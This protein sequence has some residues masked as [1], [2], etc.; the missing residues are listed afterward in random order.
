M[1][2]R[3]SDILKRLET[4]ARKRFGQ[5]FL[6]RDDT[7]D[8]IVRG[9]RVEPGD[10]VVEIGPG[11]GILTRALL[12]AGAE[13]T[14]VE[15]DRDLVGFLRDELPQITLVEGDA[16]KVDWPSLVAPGTKV[17]ANLPYNVGTTVLMQLLRSPAGFSR[18]TV[19]LQKEVVD[20]LMAAPGSR[21]YGALTAEAA[22][23]GQ[24]VYVMTVEPGAFH[25]P[26]KVRSAVVRFDR[27]DDA[28]RTGGVPAEWYDRVVRAAF[29]RRR[30]TLPNSMAGAF[31]KEHVLEALE[32]EGIDPRVRG[33][34]LS[35]EQL[36]TL[37]CALRA[38]AGAADPKP[39]ESE[40]GMR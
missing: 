23:W 16:A 14:A 1:S 7:V 37:A 26:P 27:F 13:V 36:K 39:G 18:I 28:P 10:R 8:R 30:K 33:E 35:V 25:P 17:V 6:T 40:S 2:E 32:R 3:P 21:A 38:R 29:A 34:A 12:R 19:M 4:R 9:A 11:L 20:R 31:P 24:P 15:L 22:V 5:H